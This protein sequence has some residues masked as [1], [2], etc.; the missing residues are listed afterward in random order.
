[1]REVKKIGQ[2]GKILTPRE[3]GIFGDQRLELGAYEGQEVKNLGS[4]IC[5]KYSPE[6]YFDARS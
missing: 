2:F 1:M 3:G 5:M 4:L 6:K